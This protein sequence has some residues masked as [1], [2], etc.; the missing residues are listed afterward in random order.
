M[1]GS[2]LTIALLILAA[3]VLAGPGAA[4]P[5]SAVALAYDQDNQTLTVTV[6]HDI[7]ASDP[8][9]HHVQKVEIKKNDED[10]IEEEYDTQASSPQVTFTYNLSAVE[11][12]MIEAEAYCSIY[13]DKKAQMTV[14][15]QSGTVPAASA[16]SSGPQGQSQ[17]GFEVVM[18]GAVIGAMY[19]ARRD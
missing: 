3:L 11:G 4:H 1:S 9:R 17:P 10:V 12:D 7:G 6:T 14:Q 13:G 16:K 18:G 15:G 19:M 5:P 8:A 2:L